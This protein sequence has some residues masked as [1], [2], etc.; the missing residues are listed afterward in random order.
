M[1]KKSKS[2][3]IAIL[4]ALLFLI[5]T[6][7]LNWIGGVDFVRSEELQMS[8]GQGIFMGLIG[9]FLAKTIFLD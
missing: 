6:V 4:I 1:I 2:N 7:F 3:L 8:L 5:V 9:L